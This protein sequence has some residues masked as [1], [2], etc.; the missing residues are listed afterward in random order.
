MD[1][2]PGNTGN[3]SAL[4]IRKKAHL[5]KRLNKVAR[6]RKSNYAL[7]IVLSE[8]GFAHTGVLAGRSRFFHKTESI[9]KYC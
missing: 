7:S 4:P 5:E 9:K 3:V 2:R 8:S 6:I 1:A